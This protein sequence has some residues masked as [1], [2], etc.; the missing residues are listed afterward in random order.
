[1]DANGWD[2]EGSRGVLPLLN[3]AQNML[4]QNESEQAIYF[5]DGE[6]P[7]L[8]IVDGQRS[9]NL[10]SNIWR[11]TDIVTPISYNNGITSPI[12]GEYDIQY[13]FDKSIEYIQIS[14]RKYLRFKQ[15]RSYDK[16]GSNP[17]RV[18]FGVDLDAGDDLYRY[19]GLAYP[20]QLTSEK[21]QP[22]IP[23]RYHFSHLLPATKKLIEAFQNGNQ[24][25]ARQY[26][27]EVIIPDFWNRMNEGTQGRSR[28]AGRREI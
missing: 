17:A 13:A 3:E 16:T 26:I 28:D 19:I 24:I 2:R 8:T 22:T 21:I 10:P 15:V 9:Y 11:V 4:W 18:E 25:E 7:A 20:T 1:M 5:V 14:G 6:L 23:D 27:E 12:I